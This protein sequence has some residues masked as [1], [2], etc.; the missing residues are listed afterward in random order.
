MGTGKQFP[1]HETNA[2]RAAGRDEAF[3]MILEKIIAAGGKISKDEACPLYTE[4]GQDQ[5]E[6]GSQ[7]MIEFNLNKTDFQITRKVETHL[8]QGAGKQKHIEK[9]DIPR[10]KIVMKRKSS[11]TNDWQII[12]LD[13]MF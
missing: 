6:V 4:V 13:E 3:E 7:R 5:F 12:D 11:S 9:T 10:I 8:L 2:T 1:L